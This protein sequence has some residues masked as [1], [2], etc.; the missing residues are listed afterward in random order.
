MEDIPVGTVAEVKDAINQAGTA[1]TNHEGKKAAQDAMKGVEDALN[2]SN[3]D[4]NLKG[5]P[6][7]GRPIRASEDVP[8]V[9]GE[10]SSKAE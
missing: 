8:V 1:A 7:K 10:I 6:N 9:D 2:I 5:S 4:Y 3:G